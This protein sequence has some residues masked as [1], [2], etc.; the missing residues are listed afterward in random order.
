MGTG[1]RSLVASVL[2]LAALSGCSTLSED[3]CRTA[4]WRLIGFEDGTEGHAA[5]RIGRHREACSEYGITPELG[6]YQDGRR[7][8][9]L[10]YCTA[11][12]GYEEGRRGRRY[13]GVC[14]VRA[15]Q[16][17]LD[18][19]EQ[20]RRVY[21]YER[22]VQRIESDIDDVDRDIRKLDNRLDDLEDRMVQDDTTSQERRDLR[23]EIQDIRRRQ[24]RLI[25]ERQRLSDQLYRARLDVERAERSLP[26]GYDPRFSD[27]FG[28]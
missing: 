13:E 18:G 7:E 23:D 10:R 20:G 25:F 1:L 24:D 8:G 9:L 16:D 22:I 21:E 27:D 12:N 17:F 2:A 3:E 19:Y 4:D 28:Y 26:L 6:A 14:P 5:S 11:S 15:E